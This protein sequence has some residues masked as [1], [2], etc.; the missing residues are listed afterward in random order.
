[1]LQDIL[2]EHRTEV[3]AING[4]IVRTAELHGA[5]APVNRSLWYLLKAIEQSYDARISR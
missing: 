3:D 2:H 5:T 4:A 1:M